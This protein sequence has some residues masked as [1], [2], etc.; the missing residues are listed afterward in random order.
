MCGLKER[1]IQRKLLAVAE[2]TLQT[3]VK[4]ACAAE[5]T[6]KETT[7]LHGGSMEEANKV[8]VTFPECFRCGKVNHLS[9]TCFFYKVKCHG[10]QKVGNIVRKCPEKKMESGRKTESGKT[11]WKPG[12]E[13]RKK[14][15]KQHK[16]RFIEE[17]LV[18]K[19]SATET[20]WPMFTVSNSNGKCKEFIVPV[21]IDRKNVDMELDT[22]ASITFIPRSIWTDILAAKLVERRDVKLRSYSG[23]AIPVIGGAK[24]QVAYRDQEAV[25]PVVI[26][27]NDGPVFMGHDWLTVLKLDWGHIKQISSEPVSKLDLPQTKYL[28]LFDGNLGTIKGVPAQLKLKENEIPQFFKPRSV[29]FALKENIAD[30]LHRL[31]KIGVL[32]KVEFSGWAMPVF[33]VLK[34]DDSVRI[35]GDYKVMINPVLDVPEHPMPTADDLFAQLNGGEKFKK[36]DLSSAYQ[37]VLLN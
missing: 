23:H 11:N 26:T 31:E 18:D 12:K 28:S 7:K 10:C 36:L 1:T 27:G 37:Q 3:A 13:R 14:K 32:E 25:L 15:K 2:L 19:Q 6:E 16:V 34:P 21:T 8:G 20:D 30:E 24:V 35:C 33:P 22:G 17:E 9:D 4:K 29:S 5:L